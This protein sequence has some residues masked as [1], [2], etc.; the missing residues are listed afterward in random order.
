MR[1]MILSDAALRQGHAYLD[2]G[3]PDLAAVVAETR[4]ARAEGPVAWDGALTSETV[5]GL[6]VLHALAREEGVELRLEPSGLDDREQAFFEDY[7]AHGPLAA[8]RSALFDPALVAGL[9]EA[10]FAL[11]QMFRRVRPDAG[12]TGGKA[13]IIGAYGGD[14]VGDT[15]ILGG[16]LLHLAAQFGT[17]EAEVLS[18]RP[19]HTARLVD[20]LAAPFPVRVFDYAPH[21]IGARL[22]GARLLVIAGGPMMDFPRVLAKHLG[23]IRIARSMG[24]PLHIERV[25]V[26]PFKRGISRW[27]A[28]RIFSLASSLSLRSSGDGRDP[29]LKGLPYTVGRDPAFDYLAT[30]TVLDRLTPASAAADRLLAGTEGHLLVGINLRPIRHELDKAGAS[31]SKSVDSAFFDRLADAMMASAAQSARPVTYIFYPMN[32]IEFGSSDLAAAYRLHRLVADKVDFRVWEADP[33]IDD[34][35]HLL[36]RMDAVVAMRFHAAI[37]ALSQNRPTFGVDYC[38]SRKVEQLFD[39]LGK[40][41]DAIQIDNFTADWLTQRLMTLVEAPK[42]VELIK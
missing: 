3:G 4:A 42:T 7:Y 18:H 13:V 33:D 20:G 2:G 24:I 19:A 27:A 31:R 34:V 9:Q 22:E 8:R 16:V 6:G 17:S 30:R 37:F 28:R 41:S 1:S 40:G 26:G 21:A 15:A 12:G 25:G 11:S 14:H 38:P 23:T 36:R 32:P 5:H 35:L 29:V 39:D 10:F